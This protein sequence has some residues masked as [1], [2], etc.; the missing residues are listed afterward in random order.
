[1]QKLE[2]WITELS[3]KFYCI[4][5]DGEK[6]RD[7]EEVLDV[8]GG[9]NPYTKSEHDITLYIRDNPDLFENYEIEYTYFDVE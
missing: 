4:K 8:F 5:V 6:I 7:F 1:M 9:W 3:W 2:I